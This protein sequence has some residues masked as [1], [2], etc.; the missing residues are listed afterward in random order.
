MADD[1]LSHQATTG[2][3]DVLDQI[4]GVVSLRGATLLGDSHLSAASID[5]LTAQGPTV[6]VSPLPS[7]QETP[8]DLAPSPTPW[9]P[10]SAWTHK[11]PWTT[12]CLRA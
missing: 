1:G 3:A 8:P 11:K 12:G 4:L 6:A 7:G 10:P 9:T 5:L 2:A